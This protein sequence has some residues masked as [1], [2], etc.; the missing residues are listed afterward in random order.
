MIELKVDFR[1]TTIQG[2]FLYKT[3]ELGCF[4][5]EKMAFFGN[6]KSTWFCCQIA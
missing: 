4:L 6:H 1:E 2:H 3:I 5:I